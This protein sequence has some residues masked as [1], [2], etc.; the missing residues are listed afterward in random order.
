ME[1]VSILINALWAGFFAAGLAVLLTSPPQSLIP[2]F[3]CGFAGRLIRNGLIEW[4]LTATTSVLIAAA[5]CVLVTAF[6]NQRQHL[7]S[8]VLITAI[9]PLGAAVALFNSIHGFLKIPTLQGEALTEAVVKLISNL[10]TVFTT[11]LAIALGIW[12][13]FLIVRLWKRGDLDKLISN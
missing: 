12:V 8:L 9:L 2:C 10:S 4:G 11:T 13:G 6:F 1:L 7:S 3:C 5:A